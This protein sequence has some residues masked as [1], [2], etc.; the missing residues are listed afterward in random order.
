MADVLRIKRRLFGG[1]G[2]G[3]PLSLLN[4]ELAYN[5][6]DDILYYGKGLGGGNN[7]QVVIGITGPGMSFAGTPAPNGATGAAGSSP[8]WSRG[9]HRH[10]NDPNVAPLADPVFTGDPRAPTPALT[11]GDT[12]IA[13][14]AFVRGQR[15]DQFQAPTVDVAFGSHKITGLADPQNST[16]AAN[17]NYV[18]LAI[19]GLVAKDAVRAASVVGGN[20]GLSG[21]PVTV[22]GV[23]VST[24]D[25]V[26]AKDQSNP[27]QNGV[28]TVGSGP[29]V[30]ALDFDAWTEFLSAFV[31]IQEGSTNADNGWLCTATAGG[32][33]NFTPINWVQFSGAGQINAGQGLTKS[34]NTLNVAG[35]TNRISVGADNVDIDINYVGQSSITTLGTITGSAVWN[36]TAITLAK[37]GTGATTIATGYVTS[38]GTTLSSV[39]QIPNTA[40]A[41][42]KTMAFQDANNVAITGGTIGTG[43]TGAGIT[44]DLGTF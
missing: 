29:W 14:T 32:T 24:G 9:D 15:L 4:A 27:A 30:R 21:S 19:Q 37:G 20:L 18:D 3:A 38:D 41:G 8:F 1:A 35:T 31:F 25:R 23:S 17:K 5:E 22:D 36:A 7:A 12:S 42:L 16:D 11:D 43:G 26:L 39:T 2:A 40:I 10:A 33:I 44:I 13:T 34:G 6:N 28:Y